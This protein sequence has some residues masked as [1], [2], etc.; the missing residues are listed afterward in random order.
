MDGAGSDDGDADDVRGLAICEDAGVKSFLENFMGEEG[1]DEL[2]EDFLEEFR[3]SE[4]FAQVLRE[5]RIE[6]AAGGGSSSQSIGSRRASLNE[7]ERG[8]VQSNPNQR[9]SSRGL[10]QLDE[11]PPLVPSH[12]ASSS[13]RGLQEAPR[14]GSSPDKRKKKTDKIP[15]PVVL[16]ESSSSHDDSEDEYFDG[17]RFRKKHNEKLKIRS[18]TSPSM[19][20]RKGESPHKNKN[21]SQERVPVPQ[22]PVKKK[23]S[24][25]E[26]VPKR[27]GGTVEKGFNEYIRCHVQATTIPIRD[28]RV[29]L[30]DLKMLTNLF[31]NGLPGI[32]KITSKLLEELEQC[33][34][35]IRKSKT[36]FPLKVPTEFSK[37]I[38]SHNTEQIFQ[39]KSTSL[40]TTSVLEKPLQRGVGSGK[41]SSDE[42][43]SKQ[44]LAKHDN[45]R[46]LDKVASKFASSSSIPKKTAAVDEDES[47]KISL[48]KEKS[49]KRNEPEEENE[50]NESA[51]LVE[52]SPKKKEKSKSAILSSSKSPE[53]NK[54]PE[55]V[56]TFAERKIISVFADRNEK[57][58]SPDAQKKKKDR[59][60]VSSLE[61]SQKKRLPEHG[62][63]S[64]EK[65]E[66][67]H[68]KKSDSESQSKRESSSP[69][70]SIKQ[71]ASI[72]DDKHR[73]KS[74]SVDK[75]LTKKPDSLGKSKRI[76][77]PER[78]LAKETPEA[79]KSRTKSQEKSPLK[80]TPETEKSKRTASPERSPTKKTPDT[81]K[82][83]T[84]ESPEKSPTRKTS[85]AVYKLKTE[86]LTGKSPT[87]KSA[88]VEDKPGEAMSSVDKSAEKPINVESKD[89][90]KSSVEKSS[91]ETVSGSP[92][93]TKSKETTPSP[94]KKP[95]NP[96][97]VLSFATLNEKLKAKNALPEKT[98]QIPSTS[99][100]VKEK[101]GEDNESTVLVAGQK[102]KP[103]AQKT[104]EIDIPVISTSTPSKSTLPKDM[105]SMESRT[106]SPEILDNSKSTKTTEAEKD[107]V[108]SSPLK[109]TAEAFTSINLISSN[110]NKISTAGKEES[111]EVTAQ[112]SDTI[113]NECVA[114][115]KGS[116]IAELESSEK[117]KTDEVMGPA[118]ETVHVTPLPEEDEHKQAQHEEIKPTDED[119]GKSLLASKPEVQA[120]PVIE[121]NSVPE[122]SSLSEKVNSSINI[123]TEVN[124]HEQGDTDMPSPPPS[125][126]HSHPG[127]DSRDPS[128]PEVTEPK[129][130]SSPDRVVSKKKNIIESSSDDDARKEDTD[131]TDVDDHDTPPDDGKNKSSDD[132]VTGSKKSVRFAHN[133]SIQRERDQE[134]SRSA[135]FGEF[136]MERQRKQRKDGKLSKGKI[137][138]LEE[139]MKDTQLTGSFR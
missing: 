131:I 16:L 64:K 87:K 81:G 4:S 47:K 95:F 130:S 43:G 90:T 114:V 32:I 80:K 54:S 9:D 52:K 93:K 8:T 60:G 24:Q 112:D 94:P 70:R 78:N 45:S 133:P 37:E 71:K 138:P 10:S 132:E 57:K 89:I 36:V 41:S 127:D 48:P 38:S 125:P 15:E 50:R 68:R 28:F 55:V 100:T 20:Q 106:T 116:E 56:A 134:D 75:S 99:S 82:S 17:S 110:E 2:D 105:E 72:A 34:L 49:S 85:E 58:K 76:N 44:N 108:I 26:G 7:S 96:F 40:P 118:N 128:S 29:R 126:S 22:S 91:E 5:L 97:S 12:Q 139:I 92:G 3:K 102:D 35:K 6:N 65:V 21:K 129:K 73:E 98:K 11:F 67:S 79:E 53:R 42:K 123:E 13:S 77:S 66:K 74:S 46:K 101:T 86:E 63:K 14:K 30:V 84:A 88:G 83:K 135:K 59:Q 23:S 122:P 111:I 117:E 18:S 119:E 109:E 1:L 62:N 51:L 19:K 61:K 107:S 113:R 115:S 137:D 25:L 104:S 124:T 31:P 33:E 39:Q 136:E 69:E 27:R 103:L 120:A 121:G